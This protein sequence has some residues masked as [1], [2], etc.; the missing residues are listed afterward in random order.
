MKKILFMILVL[1]TINL[2]LDL[3]KAE[4]V[5]PDA[6]PVR[7]DAYGVSGVWRS[8]ADYLERTLWVPG[9]DAA[10]CTNGVIYLGDELY[11]V[12]VGISQFRC[13]A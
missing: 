4:G 2:A 3:A 7:N 8:Y 5:R 12:P 1:S 9:V 10:S 6:Y 11:R 13:H